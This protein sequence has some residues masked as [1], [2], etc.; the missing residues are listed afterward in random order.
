MHQVALS[1]LVTMICLTQVAVEAQNKTVSS[2]LITNGTDY[3][4]RS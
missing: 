3:L 2:K 4:R 1:L